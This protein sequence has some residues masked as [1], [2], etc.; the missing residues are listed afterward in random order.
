MSLKPLFSQQQLIALAVSKT[1]EHLLKIT[2]SV[3]R[4][5]L[6][7]L[8]LTERVVSSRFSLPSVHQGLP[9]NADRVFVWDLVSRSH[10]WSTNLF[11]SEQIGGHQ[12]DVLR[13]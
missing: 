8:L 7:L 10:M 5:L 13:E 2:R 9:G 11:T 12:S 6:N 1:M 3:H 4:Y